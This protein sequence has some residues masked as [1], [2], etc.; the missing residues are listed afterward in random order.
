MPSLLK[1]RGFWI[2]V[3]LILSAAGFRIAIA[4]FLPNDE[5]DDGRVYAQL[6]RNV[7]EQHVYSLDPEPAYQPTLIRLPGYPLFLAGIYSLFGHTNNSAVRIAQALLDTGTCV[8]VA[9]LAFYWEPDDRRTPKHTCR[10]PLSRGQFSLL[11]SCWCW[12]RGPSEIAA[13]FTCFSRSLRRTRRCRANS[14]P[15]ATFAG[16]APGL[17]TRAIQPPCFGPWT[18]SP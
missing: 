9:L 8:L 11:L 10:V 3:L 12:R 15:A 7:L 18:L 14:L 6:A 1:Q 13:S 16:F 4:H 2:V 5:P 17:M